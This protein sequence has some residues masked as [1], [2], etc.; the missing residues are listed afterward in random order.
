MSVVIAL[1][2][3]TFENTL[4]FLDDERLDLSIF[5][6][7]HNNGD[8]GR[9]VLPHTIRPYCSKLFCLLIPEG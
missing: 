3:H 5:H 8:S 1:L 2:I 7:R 4:N 6:P 9:P